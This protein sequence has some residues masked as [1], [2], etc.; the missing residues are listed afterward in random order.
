MYIERCVVNLEQA[1]IAVSE[2]AKRL[3]LCSALE[4][5]G[6]TACREVFLQIKAELE[7]PLRV[8]LREQHPGFKASAEDMRKM[9][10]AAEWFKQHAA[11]GFVFGFADAGFILRS[12]TQQLLDMCAPLPC[13]FHKAF[14]ACQDLTASLEELVE[15]GFDAILTSGGADTASE[16]AEVLKVLKQQAG[17]RIGIIVAGKVRQHNIQRL[18]TETQADY[19]HFR[20]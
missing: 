16:G 9:C 12:E 4:H 11:D 10:A 20:V 14:D 13:T 2:G 17:Q 6:L 7:V 5:D 8:M 15:L 19:F 18:A 1:R 3:E